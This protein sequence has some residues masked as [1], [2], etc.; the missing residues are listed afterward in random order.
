MEQREERPSLL[1]LSRVVTEEDKVKLVWIMP[2]RDRGRRSQ[3]CLAM[4]SAADI[5]RKLI[6]K[7]EDEVKTKAKPTDMVIS[8]S[9]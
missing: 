4:P 8:D 3:A 2:S 7:E 5:Q 9:T 1:G 6:A